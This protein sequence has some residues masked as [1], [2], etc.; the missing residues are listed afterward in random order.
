MY[1]GAPLPTMRPARSHLL[2]LAVSVLLM[3][4]SSC[5]TAPD[6]RLLQY[7]NQDGFGKRYTGNVEEEEYLTIGDRVSYLDAFQPELRGTD[8]VALDGT[9]TLPEVGAVHVAGM[10]RS[11]LEALLE[12]KFAPYFE[13]TDMT[14]VIQSAGTKVYW[15]LGE[16]QRQGPQRFP[17]DLTIFEAVYGAA[18]SEDTANLGRVRLIRPDPREPF[19]MTVNVNDMIR[20]GDSTYNVHVAEND[21]IFVP[22]TMLA[23]IGYFIVS[24][25]SP[26]TAVIGR[27]SQSLF[28]VLR[29]TRFN[30]GG[31]RGNRRNNNNFF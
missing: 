1:V 30:T 13:R 20:S 26:I 16:V 28:S 29:L 4:L 23:Q 24:L 27:I 3:G 2:L 7:L 21:I 15:I 12:Q 17:G 11:E 25:I 22:P 31:G 5:Q 10:T 8:A 9:I 14:V 19:V 6:K 18:P